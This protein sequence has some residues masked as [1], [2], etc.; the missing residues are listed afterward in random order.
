MASDKEAVGRRGS[1]MVSA[2]VSG[3]SGAGSNSGVGH[4]VVFMAKTLN[5]HS[6]SLHPGVQMGTENLNVGNPAMD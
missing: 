2:S 1:L 4:Y 5:F 3:A 6:A